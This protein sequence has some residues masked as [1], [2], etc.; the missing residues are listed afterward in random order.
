MEIRKKAY[1][2]VREGDSPTLEDGLSKAMKDSEVM[3]LHFIIPVTTA[4]AA[5]SSA[6]SSRQA[7][8]PA[9]PA[10]QKGGAKGK[11]KGGV[12]PAKKL[13]VKTP[14]GRPLCFKFNN[15][16]KCTA[17]NCNYVHQCQRCL[18]PHPKSSCNSLKNDTAKASG[19]ASTTD[20]VQKE[21][22]SPVSQADV[23][24]KNCR[25]LRVLYMFSGAPRKSDVRS[26][27]ETLCSQQGMTLKMT[28]V[29]LLLSDEH[30]LSNDSKWSELAAKIKAHEFDVILMSPPCRTWSRAVW[31]NKFGP[32]PVRSRDY[33]L[34]FPWLVGE[35]REK[36]E[37]GTLLVRRCIEA[38]EI[39]P[40]STICLWEHP[41]DL[42]RARNG[43][44]ASVWQLAELRAVA[45]RR[46]METIVFHQCTYGADYP[47]PT[48]LLSDAHG[49]LQLGFAGWPV[50]NK[51]LYYMGPLPRHCGLDAYGGGTTTPSASPTTEGGAE[52]ASKAAA[53]KRAV[54]D[55]SEDLASGETP[56]YC[57]RGSGG[58]LFHDGA[59]LCS[60]GN[61]RPAFR[62][63]S[64]M[65]EVG[66]KILG[67]TNETELRRDLYKLALGKC[68]APPFSQG[69]VEEAKNIW[70][71]ALGE[72]SGLSREE[73]LH[74]NV[75]ERQPFMLAAIAEHL[76]AI[77]DPDSAAFSLEE[78]SFRTGVPIGVDGMPRVP[79]VFEAKEKWRKYEQVL[80]PG[81]KENYVSARDNAQAVQ[82]QKEDWCLQACKTGVD[83]DGRP[84]SKIWLNCVGTFGVTS[85]SYHF[86]RHF[87]AV[88]RCAQ[89][90]I[91]RRDLFQLTYVDDLL[92]LARGLGGMAGTWLCLLFFVIVGTPFSW[93][94]FGGGL[95]AEWIGFQ[96]DVRKGELG[97]SEKR[98][99]WARDWLAKTTA[100]KVVRVDEFRSAL[101]RLAFMMAAFTH[102][103]PLLGPLYSW[104]TA[105]D[106]C[107]TL[108]VPAAV[109]MVLEF[110]KETMVPEIARTKVR[111]RRDDGDHYF[112]SDA[113]AEGETVVIGGWACCDSKDRNKCRWFSVRLDR[114]NAPWV[115]ESG[116]P[117]RAIASLEL[118]GTLAS[119]V[120]F[121]VPQGVT[122]AF[123]LSAGTDNLGNKHLVTRLLTTKFPLCIVLMQLAWVLHQKDLELRLDWVPRLQ[124]READAL[125]NEDFTGFNKDL[126]VE[127]RPEDLLE[128]RFKELMIKGGELY[129]EV[130][131]LRQKRK[132]GMMKSLPSNKKLKG[133]SLI[134]PW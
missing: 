81:D 121:R 39:A 104:V 134:G 8:R 12:R 52:E 63:E 58:K 68:D 116:E 73:L 91:G 28:E 78:G 2:A 103:K 124:N 16:G 41:E 17:K 109:L 105:V 21:P 117:Y 61:K 102:F 129:D 118:L 3:N 19:G 27:L 13:H 74:V 32:K 71:Q 89:S 46:H 4:T 67:L 95:V 9:S 110:L 83:D 5:S 115:F 50:L 114:R 100:N 37:L 11:T 93:H 23:S 127:V 65:K 88:V 60:E 40:A 80:H 70:L 24:P 69:L 47:K 10:G 38:L 98:L 26:Y 15:N 49:L 59:G 107:N 14:D 101:G 66:E 34:G 57:M 77:R 22:V 48:R 131:E 96:I 123:C 54:Q 18:G 42:G 122:G 87:G 84:S 76:R 106:H 86:T 35:L 75:E 45:K 94:K 126:R 99:R 111:P 29:D 119:L 108:Q 112:R 133:S 1:R 62:Q 64:T 125:T 33:P 97:M 56:H 79:A 51:E 36:A 25:E 120:A 92:F 30:D 128:E 43:V 7:A 85:A 130:K 20:L 31:A 132:D 82:Q 53:L 55:P 72:R 6:S 44:P 90:L 113:K